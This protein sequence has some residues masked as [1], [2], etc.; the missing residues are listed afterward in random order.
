[1]ESTPATVKRKMPKFVGPSVM[2]LISFVSLVVLVSHS[3]APPDV[4]HVN[5][6]TS[7]GQKVVFDESETSE[8]V[9]GE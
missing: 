7:P 3:N 1:M 4:L 2:L 8:T 9:T 6:A 5:V